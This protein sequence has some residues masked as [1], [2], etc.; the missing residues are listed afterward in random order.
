MRLKPDNINYV[1]IVIPIS[2]DMF[3]SEKSEVVGGL[4]AGESRKESD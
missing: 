4:V 2:N 3:I 1:K